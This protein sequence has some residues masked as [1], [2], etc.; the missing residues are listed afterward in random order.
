MR[1]RNAFCRTPYPTSHNEE[2]VDHLY[3]AGFQMGN[4]AD[5]ILHVH[6][7]Q[8][9]L[10][11]ILLSKSPYLAHLM[12]TSPANA[13]TRNI[14]V[15]IEEEPEVT[16][17]VTLGYLY[18]SVSLEM[19]R[20]NNAR[21]VLAAACFLGGLPD[22]CAYA[23]E[24]CRASISVDTVDEWVRFVETIPAPPEEGGPTDVPTSVFGPYAGQLRADVFQFLVATLPHDLQAFPGS[25]GAQAANGGAS[26]LESLLHIY[27]RVPFDMFKQAIEAQELPIGSDQ[28]RFQFAK[29]AIA[30]RKKGLG[31]GVE[32]TVVLA[33]GGTT[34]SGSAVHVTRKVKKRP[35]W[36][37]TK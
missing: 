4:Y 10:H 11:A 37:V 34:S 32:E 14:H 5:T 19:L 27:A 15:P 9:R 7:R 28:A 6:G 2:I 12:S 8:Y 22:L 33:F 26:G 29:A 13:P 31:H 36:K 21:A 30:L 35:L 17:E 24:T 23:Y 18:S 1:G 16:E 20:P 3:H 25:E